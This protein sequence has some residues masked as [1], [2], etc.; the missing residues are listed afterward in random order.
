M[1]RALMTGFTVAGAAALLAGCATTH[2]ASASTTAAAPVAAQEPAPATQAGERL[3]VAQLRARYEDPASRYLA[4]GDMKVHYKDEGK[5][6]VLFMVHG[7][8]SSLRTWDVIAERLKDRYRIVRYDLPGF[9]LSDGP[10]DADMAA[11]DPMDV[12]LALARKLGIERMT[13]VGVSSGGT[14]GMYLA[15]E[16]P[17][18]I[19]R[20]IISNTP[21]D[22]V[23]TSHLVM[24]KDFTDAIAR[25]EKTGYRDQAFWN[26]FLSYFAG[27]PARISAQTR[28]EYFDFYRRVPEKHPIGLVAVIGDGKVA[29]ERMARVKQPVFQIWGGADQLLPESAAIASARHLSAARISRVVMPDVG[30]YPPLEAP[31]R[32][33][34]LIDAYVR[35][36]VPN[37]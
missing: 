21:S 30:H 16:H 36:V 27:D 8:E 26:A 3:T 29:M 1:L 12:P 4:I 9:G 28:R 20:L 14:M 24:P 17:A 11:L 22:P 37:P 32:F 23:D 34:T 13:F 25:A 18:L 7:S 5:G 33:A 15:A 35:A 6:P 31:E 2:A 10:S 19:D